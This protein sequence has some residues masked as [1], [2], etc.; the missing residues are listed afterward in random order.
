VFRDSIEQIANNGQEKKMQQDN[1]ESLTANFTPNF[2]PLCARSS[3]D[4][5]WHEAVVSLSGKKMH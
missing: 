5:C 3:Q 2:D 4:H 1:R